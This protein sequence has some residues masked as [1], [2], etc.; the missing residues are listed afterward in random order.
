ML[1]LMFDVQEEPPSV[2]TVLDNIDRYS[3]RRVCFEG[4]ITHAMPFPEP[5]EEDPISFLMEGFAGEATV[6]TTNSTTFRVWALRE[7]MALFT[8]LDFSELKRD[9]PVRACGVPVK[10]EGFDPSEK[11]TL[12]L[13]GELLTPRRKQ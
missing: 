13:V 4:R 10:G 8:R 11:R 9:R 6:L 7:G 5:S 2:A 1:Q 12:L 3:N